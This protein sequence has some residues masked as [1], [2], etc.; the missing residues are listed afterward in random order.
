M[1]GRTIGHYEIAEKLGEGGMG[2][3]YKARDVRLDRFVAL[4][5]LPAEKIAD[6]DRKRRFAQEARSASALNHPNIVTIYDIGSADGVDFIAMEYVA[7]RTLAELIDRRGMPLA[8]VL[9]YAVQIGDALSTAHAAGLVHRDLKPANVMVTG[10]GLVKVLD[11]GL[12]KLTEPAP[13]DESAV[14]ETARPQTELG[15]IVGTVAYM[16]PEQAEGKKVDA[17]S[18]IFSFG[19]VL[20]EMVTGRRPF[21]GDTGPSTMAAILAKEPAPPSSVVGELPF[22]LE[23]AILRCLR[24]EPAAALA[25]DGR[26]DGGAPGPEGR[27]GFRPRCRRWPSPLP[28]ARDAHGWSRARWGWRCSWRRR[29]P[30]GGFCGRGRHRRATRWSA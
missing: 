13:V 28:G 8:E 18:D 26:P 22:E 24:K 5:V 17:R 1:I 21:V 2:A 27:A 11:F 4:K 6:P 10:R 3:V 14:T 16:S 12:A 29:Q 9:K 20:Y 7:G 15:V 23:R 19:T 25:D 30:A